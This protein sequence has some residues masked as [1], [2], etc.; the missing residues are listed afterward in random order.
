MDIQSTILENRGIQNKNEFLNPTATKAI[1]DPYL[2]KNMKQAVAMF[3]KHMK[4]KSEVVV[5]VDSDP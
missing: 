5:L 4:E 3:T 1:L 2:L